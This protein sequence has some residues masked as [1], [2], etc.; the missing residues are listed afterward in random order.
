MKGT[1]SN[2]SALKIAGLAGQLEE[3]GRTGELASAEAIVLQ[4]GKELG[5]FQELFQ[6]L[7]ANGSTGIT[8][9]LPSS[10]TQQA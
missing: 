1:A 5:R 2:L 3:H 4:L 8:L 6:T 9:P 7:A 10:P